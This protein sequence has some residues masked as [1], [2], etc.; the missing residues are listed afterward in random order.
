MANLSRWLQVDTG[1][2]QFGERARSES[3]A[4]IIARMDLR[5]DA[6]AERLDHPTLT[7]EETETFFHETLPRYRDELRR[8]LAR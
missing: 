6:I 5:L 3:R 8:R 1:R 2:F 7:P 4:D